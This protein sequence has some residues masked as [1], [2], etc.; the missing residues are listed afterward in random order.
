MKMFL[1]GVLLINFMSASCYC[2]EFSTIPSDETICFDDEECIQEFEQYIHIKTS[3]PRA[4]LAIIAKS[5]PQYST[6]ISTQSA[7]ST[8]LSLTDDAA[9]ATQEA[10]PGSTSQK[11]A[12]ATT[13]LLASPHPTM[14]I[15][16]SDEAGD[17]SIQAQE[18]SSILR[19]RMPTVASAILVINEPHDNRNTSTRSIPHSP[20]PASSPRAAKK[21]AIQHAPPAPL[22][23]NN[24]AKQEGFYSLSD[25]FCLLFRVEEIAR[26]NRLLNSPPSTPKPTSKKLPTLRQPLMNHKGSEQ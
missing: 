3:P 16:L 26:N 6:D 9:V 1:H 12:E 8:L 17:T 15:T 2:M 5:T 21:P 19:Q 7:I 25:C 18:I 10:P 24:S 4:P 14:P 11:S 13:R 22:P 23:R 20:Q